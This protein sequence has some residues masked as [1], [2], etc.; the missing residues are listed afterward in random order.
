ME[1]T[2][3]DFFAKGGTVSFMDRLSASLG[4]HA[5]TIKIVSVYE[6]S[7]V[8][9]YS[10]VDPAD[11]PVRL[12][13]LA[14]AQIHAY[15]TGQVSLGAPILDV[16]VTATS[17]TGSAAAAA[18]PVVHVVTAGTVSAPGYSPIVI[19]KTITNDPTLAAQ[20]TTT[21]TPSTINISTASASTDRVGSAAYGIV[22]AGST[23]F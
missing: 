10:I 22:E 4:I 20:T 6:G 5:S 15:A 8:V 12:Q 9:D 14:A 23:V 21:T 2:L 17:A 16:S 7:L 13:Q 18:S 3:T 11:D 1:W 19:T